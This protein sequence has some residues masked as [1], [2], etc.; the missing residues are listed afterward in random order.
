[1]MLTHAKIPYEDVRFDI[2]D[3][4]SYKEKFEFKQ[5][6]AMEI[7]DADGK[8]TMYTQSISILRYLSL[9]NGYYPTDDAELAWEIDSALAAVYD[10]GTGLSKILWERDPEQRVKNKAEF[11]NGVYPVTLKALSNRLAKNGT[12]FLA[13]DKITTADFLFGNFVVSFI[14]NDLREKMGEVDDFKVIYEQFEPLV[15]YAETIK[16]EFAA[17]LE[18]DLSYLNDYTIYLFTFVSLNLH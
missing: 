2:A 14:Y 16:A 6:P 1:M 17:Y 4:P 5:M 13:A 3:W 12:K 9:K 11:L 8:V 7:T 10:M 18:R 15:N